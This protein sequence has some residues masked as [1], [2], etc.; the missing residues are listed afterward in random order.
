M[1]T[2]DVTYFA[3]PPEAA[4]K[5]CEPPSTI[6]SRPTSRDGRSLTAAGAARLSAL[7]AASAHF[8]TQ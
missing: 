8:R 7:A 1:S 5:T 2:E 6:R 4:K 3:C